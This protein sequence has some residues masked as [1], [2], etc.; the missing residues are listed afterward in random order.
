[1]E[2]NPK[3][4]HKRLKVWI[5]DEERE[6]VKAKAKYY[7]YKDLASYIRD[8]VIYEKV[9]YVNLEQRNE[10]YKAYADNTKELKKIGKDV[11]HIAKFATQ[12]SSNE[13]K[14][15]LDELFTIFRKQKEILKVIEQKLNLDLWYEIN[16]NKEVN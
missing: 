4:R 1:M 16:H 5:S 14:E 11:R 10:L 3:E 12:L 15:L 2:L 8:A 7:G 13:R 6:L 9:T